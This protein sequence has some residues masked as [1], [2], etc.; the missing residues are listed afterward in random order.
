MLHGVNPLA[1]VLLHSLNIDHKKVDRIRDV[2]LKKKDTEIRICVFCRTG[3]GNRA[4]YPNTVLISH[5]EYISDEDDKYDSTYAHYYF[6]VPESLK[7]QIQD[8]GLNIEDLLDSKSLKEKTDE[9]IKAIET[10][11]KAKGG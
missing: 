9:V 7:K 6:K 4:D 8:E 1:G 10:S 5:P 3:G 11:N 2:S